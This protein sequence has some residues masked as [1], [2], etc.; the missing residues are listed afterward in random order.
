VC[1]PLANVKHV[2]EEAKGSD[3]I[4][5]LSSVIAQHHQ[6]KYQTLIFCNTISSVRFVPQRVLTRPR[7][8]VDILMP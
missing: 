3:K 7:G 4:Q 6:R 5:V 8:F 2:V 1:R